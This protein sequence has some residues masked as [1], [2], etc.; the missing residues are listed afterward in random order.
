[1]KPFLVIGI[2]LLLFP[3]T[4]MSQDNPARSRLIRSISIEPGYRFAGGNNTLLDF[5]PDAEMSHHYRITDYSY[6]S[7]GMILCPVKRLSITLAGDLSGFKATDQYL[8]SYIDPLNYD[9]PFDQLAFYISAAYQFSHGWELSLAGHIL[10]GVQPLMVW[11]DEILGGEYVAAPNPYRDWL[12]HG[13]VLKQTGRLDF[14]LS[15]GFAHF[16]SK[17]AGQAG[18]RLRADLTGHQATY[19]EGS[20]TWVADTLNP[21]GRFVFTAGAGQ[22]LS[23]SLWV[24][25]GY[26]F[27]VLQNMTENLGRTVYNLFDPVRQKADISL[28]IKELTKNLG[29]SLTYEWSQRLATWYVYRSGVSDGMIDKNYSFHSLTGGIT[30]RF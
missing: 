19:L 30:W 4:L 1:M 2:T 25:A 22:K 15:G 24:Q 21:K 27:G 20:A 10:S 14:E 23:G 9:V 26:S 12:L 29:V 18:F 17:P 3:V 16:R 28:I 7:V 5:R 13:A 6:L 11:Q 8:F